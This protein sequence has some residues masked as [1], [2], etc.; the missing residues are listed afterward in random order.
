VSAEAGADVSARRPRRF[1]WPVALGVVAVVLALAGG[2]WLVLR[3]G[4]DTS[5]G[6]SA[7]ARPRIVVL[8][9]EN[10]GTQEDAYFAA[11]MT[12]EITFRLA[13]VQ[14][15][16]VTSRTTAMEYERAGKTLKRVGADLRV[17][18][19]LEGT[20]RWDRSRG[21]P[22]RVRITPQLI[23][24]SDDTHLW[25]SSYERE[26]ADVF[27]L[28][29]D[30][31]AEVVRA[32]GQSLTPQE[33]SGVARV[34][35]RDLTAYDLYLR[36]NRISSNS[37][38]VRESAEAVRLLS[39][40]VRRD[41]QFAEAH[42]SLARRHVMAYW[43]YQDR[44]KACLE[45]S[46]LSAE[47][48]V[49][50]APNIPETRLA[51]GYYYYMGH[52]DY[53]RALAETRAALR[54][55]AEDTEAI[56]LQAFVHRRAGRVEESASLLERVVAVDSGSAY[57]WHNLAETQWLL[58]RY[59]EADRGFERALALSPRWGLEYS[60]RAA[61][62]LCQGGDVGEARALL[63]RAPAAP[64]LLEAESV[65][66]QLVHLDVLDRRYD[67]AISRAR[68]LDIEAFS[69]QWSYVPLSCV[70]GEALRL[71]GNPADA[72]RSYEVALGQVE[73]QLRERPDDPRLFSA[74]G[75]IHAGLGHKD[76]ALRA[77]QTGVDL[78][79][80]S[81]EAYRGALRAEDLARVHALVG[82]PDAAIAILEDL[83]ERPAR[84][85]VPVV[86]LD[87]AW[88]PLRSH[89]RF[90]ALLRKHGARP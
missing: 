50:L 6:T 34:P 18:Y 84:L 78:M 35:T 39:E 17:D 51:L 48:A 72:R 74:L 71:K 79:P 16:A 70:V 61:V 43:F 14:A 59:P 89:P 32:L 68:A 67:Q 47:R 55:R 41:P 45:R 3:R 22:G 57:M 88:D 21:G 20:V 80:I 83:L 8:P 60:H 75:L 54:L 66:E 53:E 24:V 11:G 25:A 37:F 31:A 52:L 33:A 58:R 63:A 2:T 10:L 9:F 23:R 5:G 82:D 90:Q 27:A 76:E 65:A 46:R 49:A 81:R 1:R 56:A 40:A 7:D 12:E 64:D 13:G 26:M 62:C 87:P 85:C 73:Q 30:V 19:V 36:A 29:S 44:S 38:D 28:Q 77:A 4:R 69:S 15:L 86:R 42:A